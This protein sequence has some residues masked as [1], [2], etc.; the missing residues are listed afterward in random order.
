MTEFWNIAAY[1]WWDWMGS[2]FWQAS[3]LIL[4]V[5]GLDLLM[6]RWVWPQVRYVLWLLIFVKLL[7]PPGWH[8]PTAVVPRLFGET[9]EVL[10]RVWDR[11]F[12][13]PA[14]LRAA[15][16]ALPESAGMPQ[17][18][19][20]S[21]RP[22]GGAAAAPPRLLPQVYLLGFWLVGMGLFL[23][24]LILK[25]AKL[26]RWHRQQAERKTIP[27]WFHEL[28]VDTGRQLNLERL[29][30]IV[31]SRD[32]VTPAVYGVFRPVLLLPEHYLDDLS[33]EEAEHVLLHELCHLKRGDLWIHG[34]VLLL[35]VAYWFNPFL[36]WANRQLRHVREMCCDQTLAAR[37]Q[38]RTAAYR[39]TL[40]DTARELLTE[41]VEPGM[42]LLGVFEEPFWLVARIRWLEKKTWQHR[43]SVAASAALVTL[44]MAILVMPMAGRPAV[45]SPTGDLAAPVSWTPAYTARQYAE[46]PASGAAVKAVYCRM[47]TR[48]IDDFLWFEADARFFA[49]EEGW[50]APNKVALIEEGRTFILDKEKNRFIF[51]NRNRKTCL[52]VPLPVSRA[53]AHSAE[54]ARFFEERKRSGRVESLGDTQQIQGRVCRG[55]RLI[56]W[57][58]YGDEQTERAENVVWITNEVPFNVALFDEILVYM[59]LL[60]TNKDEALLQQ[61]QQRMQGYQMGI[62]YETRRF[63]WRTRYVMRVVEIAEKT[64]PPGVFSVPPDY[65]RL[66]QLDIRNLR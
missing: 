30:A 36:L 13:Q 32:A 65:V 16:S 57:S 59:R 22:E 24:L 33:R 5:T 6:R 63:P 56:D 8:L 10:G 60:V 29:P 39:K 54:L 27:Q 7:I 9:Q 4:V 61:M 17:E 23:I 25:M 20:G 62:D 21:G 42:G 19:T 52:E 50:H 43:K 26:R 45:I 35:Q 64:A 11:Q 15:D 40:L 18:A 31:F 41:R 47:I 12:P 14:A 53:T 28:L 44:G 49:M 51:L 58:A 46:A 66:D 48:V 38:D 3:L 1:R 55:L 37:L 34:L 2:M